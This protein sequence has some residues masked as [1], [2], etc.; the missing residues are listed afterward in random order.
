MTNKQVF[1]EGNVAQHYP[2]DINPFT[3]VMESNGGIEHLI[4]HENI[5]YSVLTDWDGEVA[6]P[7]GSAS[8]VSNDAEKYF[9]DDEHEGEWDYHDWNETDNW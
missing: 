9:D 5:L 3:G 8:I 2:V 6:D 4:V 7:T 1:E